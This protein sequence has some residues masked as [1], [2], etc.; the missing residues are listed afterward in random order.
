MDRAAL[1]GGDV[2]MVMAA[3]CSGEQLLGY[4]GSM[5]P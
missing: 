3:V 4:Q 1:Q 2:A 5:H